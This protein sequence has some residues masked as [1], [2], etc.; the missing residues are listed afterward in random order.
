MPFKFSYLQDAK[1]V[2]IPENVKKQLDNA[3]PDGIESWKFAAD[4]ILLGLAA[5]RQL[6]KKKTLQEIT[7]YK[8]GAQLLSS[9][10]ELFEVGAKK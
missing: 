7:E 1:V 3:K 4:I 8:M 9:V 10:E 5:Y 6:K 2:R